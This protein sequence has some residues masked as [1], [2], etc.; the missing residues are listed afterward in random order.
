MK[1]QFEPKII[2]PADGTIKIDNWAGQ[3][4]RFVWLAEKDEWYAILK[5]VCDALELDNVSRVADRLDEGD[6]TTSVL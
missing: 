6:L 5:D 4:I 1:K 3:E 2:K